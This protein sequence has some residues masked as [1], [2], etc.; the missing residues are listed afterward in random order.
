MD[1]AAL[2]A[3]RYRAA[4]WPPTP[5]VGRMLDKM[6]RRA[7]IM[8]QNLAR[9]DGEELETWSCR[10][11]RAAS[12]IAQRRG[13]WSAVQ[14]KLAASWEDHVKRDRNRNSIA[15][16]IYK[17][18]D[19]QWRADRRLA[20]GSNSSSAGRLASRSIS[21]VNARWQDAVHRIRLPS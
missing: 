15:H 20:M 5:T 6:Q 2:A 11:R 12:T 10:K 9:R 21:H 16:V 13:L 17:H 3:V 18:R 1:R 14:Q 8:A 7:V 4:L 19:M